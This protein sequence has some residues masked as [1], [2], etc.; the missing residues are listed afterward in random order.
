MKKNFIS[1]IKYYIKIL[2]IFMVM[3][4]VLGVPVMAKT[5]QVVGKKAL[6][7][8]ASLDKQDIVEMYDVMVSSSEWERL[9]IYLEDE[10][11]K[12]LVSTY[13][14]DYKLNKVSD[15]D[16]IAT[17]VV[18]ISDNVVY[19]TSN[20]HKH[21]YDVLEFGKGDCV[22]YALLFEKILSLLGY[23]SDIIVLYADVEDNYFNNVSYRKTLEALHIGHA[24]N[25]VIL[26][27]KNYLVDVGW[28]DVLRNES[29]ILFGKDF[30]REVYPTNK[31]G[32]G[33]L[34]MRM[35]DINLA[36][37]EENKFID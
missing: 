6:T 7:K 21:Y 28:Y 27:G 34:G 16:I 15:Y 36:K 18:W 11:N 1:K 26:D 30:Y 23:S 33:T 14:N 3:T 37:L 19:D 8:K 32:T 9:D 13:G 22:G 5:V 2:V 24:I 29:F 12:V 20:T 25:I 4:T 17:V 31:Y 10:L 35:S